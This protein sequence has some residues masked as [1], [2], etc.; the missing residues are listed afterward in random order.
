MLGRPQLRLLCGGLTVLAEG[1]Q[2]HGLVGGRAIHHS[3]QDAL[4][5]SWLVAWE[6]SE[7]LSRQ[8]AWTL[9]ALI[10]Q[11][12][13]EGGTAAEGKR[14]LWLRHQDFLQHSLMGGPVSPGNVP[15]FH[16][17]ARFHEH[18]LPASRGWGAQEGPGLTQPVA[19]PWG[20]GGQQSSPA[21]LPSPRERDHRLRLKKASHWE[22]CGH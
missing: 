8:V 16:F 11:F 18:G 17:P 6:N 1:L 21:A 20:E 14:S 10:G 7:V 2:A 5:Q 19:S 12:H 9:A 3:L 22:V 13:Q 4:D 15:S